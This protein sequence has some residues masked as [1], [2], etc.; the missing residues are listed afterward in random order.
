MPKV[1]EVHVVDNGLMIQTAAPSEDRDGILIAFTAPDAIEM[2]VSILAERGYPMTEATLPSGVPVPAG[3]PAPT[4]QEVATAIEP[5]NYDEQLAHYVATN[6]RSTVRA[7]LDAHVADGFMEEY[8]NRLGIENLVQ[9][10]RAADANADG[11]PMP[12]VGAE[13]AVEPAVVPAPSISMDVP[14][15]ADVSRALGAAAALGEEQH[16]AAMEI[17]QF[18]G[19]ARVTE[20]PEDKRVEAIAKANLIA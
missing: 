4:P 16:T 6:D 20:I 14:S 15:P 19:A 18:Y 3:V 2:I 17:L 7:R 1:A 13:P 5:R 8:N 9:L 10:L 11:G 12:G